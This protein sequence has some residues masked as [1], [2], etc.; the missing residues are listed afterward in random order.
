MGILELLLLS[1]G[2]AMDAFAVSISKG[3]TIKQYS[4][5][6]SLICGAWFG[7]FQALMPMIGW[8]LGSRF[9]KWISIGAPWIAFILLSLIGG[10]M[11]R[12]AF[13]KDEEEEKEDAG[14]Q[15]DF[16]FKA[17][18]LLAVATSIDALAVGITFVAVPVAVLP[19]SNLA[20]TIFGV[21][22]IGVVTFVISALGVRI[23]TLFGTRF[24]SG[25]EALG[26]TILLFIGLKILLEHL[27][28][29]GAM[30]DPG[31]VFG[32]LLPL[33]GT[34]IGSALVYVRIHWTGEVFSRIVR[35]FAGLVMLAVGAWAAFFSMVFVKE[36]EVAFLPPFGLL[37]GGI[38]LGFLFQFLLDKLVPHLHYREHHEDGLHSRL[39]PE[40][41]MVLSEFLHHMP[42][43][44]AL[45]SVFAVAFL[46]EKPD[47]MP[48]WLPLV[49]SGALS[50]H[51]TPEAVL[52]SVS[53]RA[54]GATTHRSFF[55]GVLSGIPVPLVGIITLILLVLFPAAVPFAAPFAAGAI[56]FTVVE[57]L[58][59][60]L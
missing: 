47:W 49:L 36:T 8:L 46:S 57:S 9:E 45:G 41:K 33:L 35:V 38:L 20:N 34:I 53:D 5:R 7:A 16:A 14:H 58:F 3:L 18:L 30:Q 51:N 56:L 59:P 22:V 29:A 6:G 31:N 1:V 2:L 27:D 54:E 50:V 25:S 48:A 32:M 24:K 26:G 23:G 21:L 44:L 19:A 40:T 39:K 17:M 37:A 42:E 28:K 55:T 12:E 10:N 60:R 11:L 52:L 4:L 15:N 13:S 43:G